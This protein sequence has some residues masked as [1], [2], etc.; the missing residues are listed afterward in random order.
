MLQR[1]SQLSW[2]QHILMVWVIKT[3]SHSLDRT[4]L[5]GSSGS[6][7]SCCVD[8]IRDHGIDMICVGLDAD[9][10]NHVGH[11]REAIRCSSKSRVL[12]RDACGLM[13]TRRSDTRDASRRVV[14]RPLPLIVLERT[15]SDPAF[16]LLSL[17]LGALF[18]GVKDG[19]RGRSRIEN[20]LRQR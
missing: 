15:T 11:W 16:D 19:S 10:V 1:H 2:A 20:Q 12:N 17:A 5:A 6:D 3:E 8:M 9:D 13:V 18:S 7:W 4:I 14:G